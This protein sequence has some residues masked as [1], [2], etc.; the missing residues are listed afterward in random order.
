M[1]SFSGVCASYWNVVTGS[2]PAD[3]NVSCASPTAKP[4]TSG[5]AVVPGP[6]ETVSATA[7]PSST[8]TPAAG[9]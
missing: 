1:T 9:S 5:T 4:V 2:K 6:D 3:F 8:L 7:E